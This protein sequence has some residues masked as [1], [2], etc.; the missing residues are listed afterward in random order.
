M[1]RKSRLDLIKSRENYEIQ[2]NVSIIR[3]PQKE[4]ILRIIAKLL[5]LE[6]EGDKQSNDNLKSIVAEFD[7]KMKNIT[8][9]DRE[10]LQL[11]LDKGCK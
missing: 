11:E 10:A 2:S 7:R 5:V 1:T 6:E 8:K 3:D 4:G 9:K